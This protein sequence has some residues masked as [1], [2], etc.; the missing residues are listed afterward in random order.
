MCRDEDD[1]HRGNF[2]DSYVKEL[3]SE[4]GS[5][6]GIQMIAPEFVNIVKVV[7]LYLANNIY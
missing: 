4:I 7:K 1:A 5:I 6:S 3:F 2:E